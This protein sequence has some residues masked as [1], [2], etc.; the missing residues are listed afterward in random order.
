M[1]ACSKISTESST[2]NTTD[3]ARS[4]RQTNDGGYIVAGMTTSTNGDVVGNDGGMDFWIVKLNSNGDLVWQ[5]TYGD[6]LGGEDAYSIKQ[7]LDGGYIVAGYSGMSWQGLGNGDITSHNGNFDYWVIKLDSLGNL[8]WQKTLGGSSEDKAC[9]VQ[10][11]NDGGFI[12][13]G[14]TSSSNGNVSGSR[15]TFDYWV[16]KLDAVGNIQ[17]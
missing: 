2:P 3:I 17:W 12:V 9:D 8:Q 10:Q 15:S 7:T 5:K 16:V 13:T 6:T 11:T 1:G 4:V 14:F